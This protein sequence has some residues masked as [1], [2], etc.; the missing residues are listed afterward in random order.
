[1]SVDIETPA[2]DSWSR[3][4]LDLLRKIRLYGFKKAIKHELSY[5]SSD[6]AE[7]ARYVVHLAT[8]GCDG[9][10][11]VFSADAIS[12][13]KHA[14]TYTCLDCFDTGFVLR[15][16]K[17]QRDCVV[18]VPCEVL[19]CKIERKKRFEKRNDSGGAQAF[20]DDDTLRRFRERTEARNASA[21]DTASA[22]GT[23]TEQQAQLALD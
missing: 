8:H 9:E 1:M 12:D 11:Y 4:S 22:E 5:P 18:S 16:H 15:P 17:R 20:E 19:T 7:W 13:D 14:Q 2:A 23:S 6:E 3:A 21:S 10:R